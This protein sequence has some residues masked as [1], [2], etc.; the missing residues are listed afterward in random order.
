MDVN[1]IGEFIKKLRTDKGL[2]QTGLGDL[3]PVDRSVISKW[4]RGEVLPPVDKM[5]ML[6][7]I[8]DISIDELISGELKTDENKKE[9]ENNLFNYLLKQDYKYK[10]LKLSSILAVLICLVLMISFLIY[11]FFETHDS[12]KVY[13]VY[14]SSNNYILKDG[15]LV[16]TREKS[17]L[18]I[19][20]INLKDNN[21]NKVYDIILYYKENGEDKIIYEGDSDLVL[22]DMYGYSG[23]INCSN[24][25]EIKDYLYI[26]IDEEEMK[27]EL[28]EAYKNDNYILD[29]WEEVSD[30]KVFSESNIKINMDKINKEFECDKMFCKKDT[31]DGLIK[32]DKGNNIIYLKN[33]KF[34]AQFDLNYNKF[35]YMSEDE[36]FYY[37][38][39]I[40]NC[41]SGNCENYKEIYD[42]YF[43]N[44]IS[45]YIVK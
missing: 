26:K 3:I 30:E 9:H 19:G 40:L 44:L 11:Y 45:N 23:L 22:S 35:L 1:K 16:I 10:K 13:R 7:D 39:N 32:Y 17:Y 15:L 8:F 28:Y 24:L 5:K 6:C 34:K 2:S 41:S 29:D 14:G 27:L 4:E 37:E 42:K 31:K 33:E 20:S 12:E 25:N 38:K 43:T 18:K 21:N 36:N